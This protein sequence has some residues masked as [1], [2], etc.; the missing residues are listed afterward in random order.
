MPRVPSNGR[1]SGREVYARKTDRRTS[2]LPECRVRWR[3]NRAGSY[4]S[5][6]PGEGFS[7]TG[8]RGNARAGIAEE[9]KKSAAVATSTVNEELRYVEARHGVGGP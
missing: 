2:V 7:G 8:R 4:S 5:D 6:A 3:F 1:R 9:P